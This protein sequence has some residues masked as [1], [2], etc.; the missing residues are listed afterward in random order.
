METSGASCG[1]PSCARTRAASV[2]GAERHPASAS[3]TKKSAD[4]MP[5]GCGARASAA[6]CSCAS[7]RGAFASRRGSGVISARARS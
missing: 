4:L 7:G 6:T 3:A 2:F 5:K 1:M